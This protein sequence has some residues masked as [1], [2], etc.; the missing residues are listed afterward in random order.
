MRCLDLLDAFKKMGT[1][2][3][4]VVDE[5]G[6]IQGVVSQ[7]SVLRAIVGEIREEGRPL[8]Q[9]LTRREDGALSLAGTMP[10]DEVFELIEMDA[11][12]MEDAAGQGFTTLAGFVMTRLGRVPNAG[13]GFVFNDRSFEVAEKS[14]NRITRVVISKIAG[15]GEAE[16]G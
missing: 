3:A 4:V 7:K 13:D 2:L 15:G 16:S 10:I 12:D 9:G 11:A 14:G 6:D 5:Y 8:A 1:S